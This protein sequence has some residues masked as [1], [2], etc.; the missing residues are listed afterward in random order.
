M[1]QDFESVCD[2]LLGFDMSDGE[3][4]GFHPRGQFQKDAAEPGAIARSLNAAFLIM[5]GGRKQP[6]FD[7]ARDYLGRSTQSSNWAGIAQFYL[8]GLEAIHREIEKVSKADH[9]F[10]ARLKHLAEWLGDGVNRR[11][12]ESRNEAVWSVFFPEGN[13]LL[14]DPS[15]SVKLLKNRRMVEI[16]RLNPEP[17]REPAHEILFSSNVLL[18][19][20]DRSRPIDH[21]PYSRDFK[22]QLERIVR[23]PQRYWYDHPIQIGTPP[24]HNELLYGLR[25]LESALAFERKHGAAAADSNLTCILSVSVTHEGLH[26]LARAYIEEEL[27]RATRSHPIHLAVFTE[28]DT[29]KI[30]TDVLAP[31]ADRYLEVARAEEY[32]AMFGV[33]GEYGRHYTFLKAIAAFWQVF[34]KSGIKGTFKI[35]LDQVFPQEVLVSQSGASA[36]EHLMTPLWG[37]YGNDARG[38][39]LELG[40]IAGALVNQSDIER[41]LYAPDVRLPERELSPDEVVFFS[42]LPQAISTEA[43]MM[44]RYDDDRLDGVRACIERVHVTGGTN[45]IRIDSLRRHRPFTPS[46]IGRAEDQ[47]YL[48]SVLNSPGSRLAYVHK[49]GLFMRHDKKGFAQEAIRSAE[50]GKIVGDYVRILH[51]TAY[52]KILAENPASLKEQLDP[53]TGCFISKI[54]TTIVYL[55]LALKAATF[56]EQDQEEN[57]VELMTTGAGRI[58]EVLR[59]IQDGRLKQQVEQERTGW[60][61][62]YDVLEAVEEAIAAEDPFALELRQAAQAIVRQCM[63]T[64]G[65]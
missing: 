23:E 37:A 22:E 44:A 5:L 53:F 17:I 2:H 62:Y 1:I 55:R 25:H 56:F 10:A 47:A 28:T 16:T 7:E 9:D 48:L 4:L 27:S 41:T 30:V 31:A 51:Y 64:S 11:V 63:V 43:E 45:G 39:P 54:P 61:M 24:Q 46:F 42:V 19:L 15:E 14:A 8:S 33:D 32:L 21:L 60:D 29:R 59:T 49:D 38:R 26:E 40:M 57:A 6:A 3:S 65:S 52:A 58:P 35:D 13:D 18:T 34:I 50:I 20:P 36:F 12:P